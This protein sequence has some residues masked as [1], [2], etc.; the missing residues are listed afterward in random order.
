MD[1]CADC[2]SSDGLF[3]ITA[4]VAWLALWAGRICVV[5][6]PLPETLNYIQ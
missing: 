3:L 1:L 2:G 4:V 6:Q 5:A